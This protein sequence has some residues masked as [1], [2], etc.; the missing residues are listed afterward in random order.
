M[1]VCFATHN[2]NKL[3]EVSQML[4]S[5]FELVGLTDIGCVQEIPETGSSLEEN[6]RIKAQYVKDRYQIS[7]FADDTGLE[8]DALNGAP[9]VY[10][11]RYAGEP[12][13]SE[14]NMD[15]L[16]KNMTNIDHRLARFRTVI[17]FLKED[18]EIQFEGI[19][20]GVITRGRS[21]SK[22]FGYDPI[23]VPEGHQVTF[24][25]M[26]ANDKNAISHRGRAVRKLVDYMQSSI[27]PA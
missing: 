7:C 13:D 27:A 24:A 23:F 8:V 17:T 16:L 6:S 4:G 21:G 20:N 5:Q 11:A 12:S 10:S 15:H 3:R 26:S 18:Q 14:K 9:G 22:G 19:V 2:I 1:K 25:E